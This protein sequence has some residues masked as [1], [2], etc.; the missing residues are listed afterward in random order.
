MISA[1]LPALAQ[2]IPSAVNYVPQ[3][4]AVL[5]PRGEFGTGD[6]IAAAFCYA[7]EL[8][9]ILTAQTVVQL[10][11]LFLN[12]SF[13]GPAYFTIG[14]P[15]TVWPICSEY[16]WP[17]SMAWGPDTNAAIIATPTAP[18]IE[19]AKYQQISNMEI[20]VST[21][22]PSAKAALASGYPVI[23][24]E[25]PNHMVC[26]MGYNDNPGQWT[27]LDPLNGTTT[28][29]Y[30]GYA[31]L[32]PQWAVTDVLFTQQPSVTVNLDTDE[33]LSLAS[34]MIWNSTE[35][36][37]ITPSVTPAWAAQFLAMAAG[38]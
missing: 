5:P 38:A 36:T 17:V 21:D 13:I 12:N 27:G 10:S 31:D 7:T 33:L 9:G 18:C 3:Y 14:N 25:A 24:Y 8:R 22:I 16:L 30:R 35:D 1:A 6:C 11:Q 20:I 37:N 26:I 29:F 23:A 19:D 34:Q 15:N 4:L 2:G 32:Q 28:P